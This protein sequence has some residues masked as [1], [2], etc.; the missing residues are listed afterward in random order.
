M[1]LTDEFKNKIRRFARTINSSKMQS[2]FLNLTYKC[3]LRCKYCY[4]N[5]A[6]EDMS[7]EQAS[8]ILKELTKSDGNYARLI[9][10]FGGEPTLKVDMIDELLSIYYNQLDKYTKKRKTRYGIITSFSYKQDDVMKLCEKYPGLELVIS[11]DNP[12]NE[13]RVYPNGVPL[14]LYDV[15]R[16]YPLDKYKS[17]ICIFK[18]CNGRE[19]KL[20][21][22]LMELYNLYIEYGVM[23]TWSHN[24][25][26]FDDIDYKVFSDNYSKFLSFL[27]NKIIYEYDVYIPKIVTMEY[28]LYTKR[29]YNIGGCGLGQ[30]IFISANGEIYPCAIPN[31][32]ILDWELS[33][34]NIIEKLDY[35]EMG[36]LDNPKCKTCEIVSFCSGGCPADRLINHNN[37]LSPNENWCKYSKAIYNAYD[38]AYN[39]LSD[40]EKNVLD[41]AITEYRVGY[42]RLCSSSNTMTDIVGK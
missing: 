33:N 37:I 21:N 20:F 35:V 30:E 14:N 34:P 22:D 17:N 6:D 5:R 15:I 10:F 4:I 31:R 18:T 8:Y 38:I 41:A 9:T 36:L 29:V 32:N 24:K 42:Y 3:P 28:E 26:P 16:R 25:T 11:Y 23:Y 39:K 40:K 27:F 1:D 2:F 12:N 19:K 13:Q 7:F